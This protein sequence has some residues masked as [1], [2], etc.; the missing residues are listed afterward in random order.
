M[1][2]DLLTLFSGLGLPEEEPNDE[3]PARPGALWD[4]YAE[5]EG[6]VAY[7]GNGPGEGPEEL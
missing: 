7:G 1:A 3:D 2:D 6:G 5:V 4:P